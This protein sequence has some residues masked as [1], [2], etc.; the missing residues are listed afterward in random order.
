MLPQAFS[1]ATNVLLWP[2]DSYSAIYELLYGVSPRAHFMLFPALGNAFLIFATS[3]A[4]KTLASLAEDNKNKYPYVLCEIRN[5]KG[6]LSKR[7][8]VEFYAWDL[9]TNR[10][11]RKQEFLSKKFKT[12]KERLSQAKYLKK[13]IDKALIEGKVLGKEPSKSPKERLKREVEITKSTDIKIALEY[14]RNAK[15]IGNSERTEQVYNTVYDRLTDFLNTREIKDLSEVNT[16]LMCEFM[17]SMTAKYKLGNTTRNNYRENLK[18][19]FK[20]FQDRKIIKKNPCRKIKKLKESKKR[21]TAYN[22]Q[23]AKTVKDFLI[24]NDPQL[25]LYCS[26][27]YYGYLRPKE[28]RY[29]QIKYIGDDKILVPDFISYNGKKIRVSKNGKSEYIVIPKGLKKLIH[30]FGLLGFPPDYFVFSTLQ[31]PFEKHVSSNYFNKRYRDILDN[32][33]ISKD[34]T[35]YSWKHTGV[36]KLY[37]KIKDI[38]KI[39]QQCRHSKMETTVDYLRDLGLFDN[40]EVE[41]LF[42]EF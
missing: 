7:W 33:K 1:L 12:A 42:P 38:R 36:I 6:D 10:L 13:I 17:D 2:I 11:E 18:S 3:I 4:T 19:L 5:R 22:D 41:L 27:I 9:R 24:E 29:L 15:Q 39:Q 28:L 31:K 34:H 26:F 14:A 20:V 21:H 8:Y 23:E 16:K 35:A 30:E 40:K 25:F 32:L 37:N